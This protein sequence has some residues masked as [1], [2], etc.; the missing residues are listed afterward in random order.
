MASLGNFNADDYKDEYTPIPSGSYTA[1][2]VNSSERETNKKDGKMIV[3]KV[4]VVDGPHKGRKIFE[5]LNIVNPNE[6]AVEI[7]KSTL[8]NVC[9]AVGVLHPKDTSELHNKPMRIWVSVVP[10]KDGYPPSNKIKKWESLTAAAP[11]SA[12]TPTAP[13]GSKPW[14]KKAAAPA[15]VEEKEPIF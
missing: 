7:A 14:E 5:N 2:I 11:A 15:P 4:D 6:T 13:A 9:R 8:A 1:M 12:P 3:L 10:E